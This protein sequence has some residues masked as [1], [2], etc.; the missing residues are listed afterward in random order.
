MS[1]VVRAQRLGIWI[2]TISVAVVTLTDACFS[3]LVP[4]EV[5]VPTQDRFLR[6]V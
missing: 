3:V 1:D 2:W 5:C 4:A 6:Y